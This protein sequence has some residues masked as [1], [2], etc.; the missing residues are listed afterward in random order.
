[1]NSASLL[2]NSRVYSYLVNNFL[3]VCQLKNSYYKL[4]VDR[5]LVITALLLLALSTSSCGFLTPVQTPEL[6]DDLPEEFREFL[7]NNNYQSDYNDLEYFLH[8]HGVDNIVPTWRLLQ[9]GSEWETHTLPRFAMP[10]RHL[11]EQMVNTLIFIK[12][13]LMPYIGPVKVLSGFRTPHYNFAAGGVDRSR[14]L[15]FSALDLRPI[16]QIDRTSLHAI[17]QDRWDT[18]GRAY[19]LGMGLYKDTRFHIDTGGYRQ[20]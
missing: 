14:H 4:V 1:M 20:W 7:V 10:E 19:K 8:S 13:E 3:A 9:Q 18:Y 16:Q 6:A 11:W 17:L 15:I 2:I 12:H 5:G